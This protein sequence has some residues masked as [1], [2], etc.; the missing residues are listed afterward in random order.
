MAKLSLPS[1]TDIEPTARHVNE[2]IL[3]HPT[4]VKPAQNGRIIQSTHTI[5]RHFK[6]LIVLSHYVGV[7]CYTGNADTQILRMFFKRLV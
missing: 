7:V 2:T 4:P 6:K 3:D 1:A 5:L